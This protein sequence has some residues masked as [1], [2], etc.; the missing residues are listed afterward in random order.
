LHHR[1][2]IS[3]IR[4]LTAS[5]QPV[6]NGNGDQLQAKISDECANIEVSNDIRKSSLQFRDISEKYMESSGVFRGGGIVPWP[7]PLGSWENFLKGLE[8][9]GRADGPLLSSQKGRQIFCGRQYGPP[10]RF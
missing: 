7:P 3:S 10:P 8:T 5:P 1:H 4:Q 2:E 9:G 6:K